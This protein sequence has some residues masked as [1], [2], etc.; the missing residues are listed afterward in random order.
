MKGIVWAVNA[1]VLILK[2][3]QHCQKDTAPKTFLNL[4]LAEEFKMLH[5]LEDSSTLNARYCYLIV[6]LEIN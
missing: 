4:I 2:D 6:G 3:Y 1:W 5:C